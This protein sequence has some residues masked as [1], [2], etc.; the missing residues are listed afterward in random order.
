MAFA[1]GF[2]AEA[3]RMAEQ[4]RSEL[5]LDNLQSI[6]AHQLAEHLDI[7]VWKLSTIHRRVDEAE[8]PGLSQAIGSLLTNRGSPLSAMTV[9]KGRARVIVHNDAAEP[10][11]QLSNLTHELAHGLLM[12]DPT[13]AIDER[14]RRNWRADIEDEAAFLGGALIITGKG[15]RWIAKVGISMEQAARRFGCSEEMVRW[16]LNMSGARR[17]MK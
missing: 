3:E 11:R 8:H 4:T 9:F 10:A 17:L 13:P 2:K 6:D 12:H 15:A 16:R 1:R 5:G 7:P 14:G